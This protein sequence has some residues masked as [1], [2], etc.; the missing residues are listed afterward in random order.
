MYM[1]ETGENTDQ[2]IGAWTRLMNRNN[3]GWT[4]WPYKKMSRS[5]CMRTIS[6]PENWNQIVEFTQ[7]PRNNYSEIRKARPDQEAAKKAMLQLIENMKFE[8]TQI[9][10]G[11]IKAMGKLSL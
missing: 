6:A 5:S 1:G 8:N 3:I 7:A 11:Y 10:E 9:N 4:Y 2:W